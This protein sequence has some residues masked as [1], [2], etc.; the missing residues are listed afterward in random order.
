MARKIFPL[1]ERKL[2]LHQHRAAHG[3][4]RFASESDHLQIRPLPLFAMA[5]CHIDIFA[6]KIHMLEGRT[7]TQIDIRKQLAELADPRD[8][9][10]GREIRRDADCQHARIVF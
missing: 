4:Q 9:P 3:K 8:K 5:H 1:A 6:G 10:F 2:P 7:N